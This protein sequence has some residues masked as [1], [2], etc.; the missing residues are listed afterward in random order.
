MKNS[1]MVIVAPAGAIRTVYFFVHSIYWGVLNVVY[2]ISK[3]Y[4]ELNEEAECFPAQFWS[5]CIF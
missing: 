1:S 2:L 3:I 5:I 4:L